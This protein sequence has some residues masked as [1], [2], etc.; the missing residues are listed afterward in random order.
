MVERTK[1]ASREPSQI[2]QQ[3]PKSTAL[4]NAAQK[5]SETLPFSSRWPAISGRC[6]GTGEQFCL[7][8]APS[9]QPMLHSFLRGT[10]LNLASHAHN[11][12][13]HN[14]AHWGTF[15]FHF[16]NVLV[17]QTVSPPGL[18]AGQKVEPLS[19]TSCPT[20]RPACQFRKSVM[21][22]TWGG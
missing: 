1:I 3:Q 8:P 11:V 14:A 22:Y 2:H 6:T 17:S 4:V 7:N 21:L 13:Q 5:D 10:L 12:Y 9:G 15:S 18:V 16:L 20:Y 19:P